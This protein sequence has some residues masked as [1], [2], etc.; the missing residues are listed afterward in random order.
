MV[1][2]R[3]RSCW[4]SRARF[5][6]YFATC[7]PLASL[8]GRLRSVGCMITQKKCHSNGACKN[9]SRSD[10]EAQKAQ[11]VGQMLPDGCGSARATLNASKTRMDFFPKP[12]EQKT[13][14]GCLTGSLSGKG[15]SFLTA[16]VPAPG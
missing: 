7:C 15:Q 14:L 2:S 16:Q 1:V 10:N 5:F 6:L 3:K 12:R 4:S 8:R 13:P 9:L 11:T